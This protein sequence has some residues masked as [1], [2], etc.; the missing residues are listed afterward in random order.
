MA[1]GLIFISPD[2]PIYVFSHHKK[3]TFLAGKIIND[4][5]D[6]L[7]L[8]FCKV[9]GQCKNILGKYDIVL[10]EHSLVSDKLL[11]IDFFGMH[12]IRE[13][14]DIVVSGFQYQKHTAEA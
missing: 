8:K 13:P 9:Y 7:S 2:K 11:K 10:F 1:K 4:L 14:R 5:S 12:I 6:L 3:G